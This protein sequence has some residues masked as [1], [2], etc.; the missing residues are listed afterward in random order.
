[1]KPNL[2][3]FPELHT[4][5]GKND[6]HTEIWKYHK[7]RQDFEEEL[8]QLKQEIE[9]EKPYFTKTR[10]YIIQKAKLRLIDE[11]LGTKP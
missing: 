1:M 8:Q 3:T 5:S 10:E 7:W 6:C 4:P 2:K 9:K 11:I